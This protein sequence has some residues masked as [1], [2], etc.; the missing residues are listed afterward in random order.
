MKILLIGANGQLGFDVS[1]M[2]SQK[3]EVIKCDKRDLDITNLT[4]VL[5]QVKQ[6]KPDMIINSAAYTDVD[7]CENNVDLAYKVNALGVRNLAVAAYEN[8][9]RILHIST[10]FV[11]D[12]EKKEP[13]IEFDRP[14]PLSI[15]GKSKWAG[16]VMLKEICQ[17]YYILRTAWLYGENG[18]NFVKTMLRLAEEKDA[19]KVVDDQIGSPTYTKDLVQV[20]EMIIETEAYG[21]YHVSNDG[22]C[23]WYEFA[24]KIFELAGKDVQV[25][26]ITTEELARPAKRPKYSVLK[27]FMLELQFDYYIR[28]WEEALKE[29]FRK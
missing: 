19:V 22:Q 17:R 24:K 21:T 9:S 27:N 4:D 13:Y 1:K 15:Y 5:E 2:L 8:R 11:F 25:L 23:S 14:N 12:G 26:P 16:E 10:D 6:I 28:H 20:I 18:R 7:S 3:H 29:Y